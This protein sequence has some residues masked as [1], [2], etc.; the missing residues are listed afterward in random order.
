MPVP[1]SSEDDL[2]DTRELSYAGVIG[3]S[4]WDERVFSISG[5]PLYVVRNVIAYRCDHCNKLEK[6]EK[7]YLENIAEGKSISHWV[8]YQILCQR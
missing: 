2:A 5:Q 8:M 1:R 3:F 6:A 7:L 4:I